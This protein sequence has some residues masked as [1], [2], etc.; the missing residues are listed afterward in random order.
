M[1]DLRHWL[2]LL[3]LSYMGKYH[4]KHGNWDWCNQISLNC[5]CLICCPMVYLILTIKRSTW[6][7]LG[8]LKALPFL[9]LY[10][11][12]LTSHCQSKPLDFILSPWTWNGPKRH[13]KSVDKHSWIHQSCVLHTMQRE[14]IICFT[15][16]WSP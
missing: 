8:L 1:H 5:F 9:E 2:P 7:W 11:I 6:L 3:V 10:L 12:N 14:E 4:I 15:R 16:K 13:P